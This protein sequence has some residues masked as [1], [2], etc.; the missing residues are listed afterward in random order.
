M[1]DFMNILVILGHPNPCSFNHAIAKTAVDTLKEMGHNVVFHDLYAE[2][3]NPV[4]E[5][6]EMQNLTDPVARRH[7]EELANAEGLL[8]IHPIW[9]GMPPAIIN[10]WVDRVFRAGIA[11]RFQQVASGEGVPVG[12]LKAKAAVIFNTSNTKHEA[13]ELRCK[14]VI[15]N[16]WK[17]C[18]LDTCGIK[19]VYRQLFGPI[20]TSAEQQRELWLKEVMVKIKTQFAAK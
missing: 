4:L 9:W 13:E 15:G 7:C 10:G 5:Q 1:M 2:K 18:I 16:L 3:F 17:V 11:Y 12:L 6:T 14:D 8:I 20:I 19:N